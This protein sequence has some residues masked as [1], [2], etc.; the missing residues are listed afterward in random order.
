MDQNSVVRQAWE[1]L[2]PH[3]EEQGFE[4]VEVEFRPEGGRRVLRV[5]IDKPGGVTIDDC[6]D[7]SNLLSTALDVA[8]FISGT[9]YLEVSSPGIDRPVRKPEDFARFVGEPV[10]LRA[11]T[12]VQGRKRF[13]GV[14]TGFEDGLIHLECDGEPCSVHIENLERA[15]LDR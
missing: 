11:Q 3:L 7:M 2:P 5:Y 15:N 1:H 10:K 13:A 8:D 12:A 4:L 6:A 9:Y 14:L